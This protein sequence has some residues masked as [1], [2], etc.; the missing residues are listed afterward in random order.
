M[1]SRLRIIVTGL[2]G[3]YPLGG[4]AWDYLHYLL[5]LTQLGHDVYY[6]ENTGMW[7]FDPVAGGLTEDSQ[8]TVNY[9]AGLMRRFGFAD[10]WAYCFPWRDQWFGLA[11]RERDRVIGSADLLL[12]VSG[13]LER[14]ETYRRVKRM[15]YIDTDPLFT[16]VKLAQGQAYFRAQ[17]DAHD[18]HFSFGERLSPVVPVTGHRWR[19]T[20]QPIVLA[21]W[22]VATAAPRD[23]MTTVMNWTSYKPVRYGGQEFGQK[24]VEFERFIDLPAQVA[25]TRLELA[26]NAGKVRATP[27]ARLARKGWLV[28]DPLRV[29]P[30]ID[31][32]RGYIAASKAE[33]SV[34]KHAYVAGRTGW[35]SCRSACYLAS[36]RPVIAQDT[37]Y[38]AVLPTGVGLLAFASPAAAVDAIRA[39]ESN[40]ARH[41]RAARELAETYFDAAAVLGKLL[42]E[43]LDGDA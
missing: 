6:I 20:R 3:Q 24:D 36:G 25:P 33:W 22:P 4:V 23:V 8:F 18:R 13:S 37:G 43:A 1:T 31:S 12:N 27:R 40:Y 2:I 32:Y 15:V 42:E 14:P 10:R 34:A 16:Q 28:V 7:P 30:D 11:E 29:C 19:P 5:G 26:V 17:V 9:L 39:V 41:A 38:S 21:E 35:F